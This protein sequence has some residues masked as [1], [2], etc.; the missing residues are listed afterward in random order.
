VRPVLLT[1][2]EIHRH[3]KRNARSECQD[4]VKVG[5]RQKDSYKETVKPLPG[6][7]WMA[8][9][10]IETPDSTKS[11]NCQSIPPITGA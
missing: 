1:P 7:I 9:E 8:D 6:L 10:G 4:Y 3:V 5:G 11:F 2:M